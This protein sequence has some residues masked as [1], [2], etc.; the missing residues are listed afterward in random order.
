M[1]KLALIATLA[2]AML[3]VPALAS[4]TQN[5]D[6]LKAL[7][8]QLPS[9]KKKTTVAVILPASLPFAAKVPKLYATGAG[10]RNAWSFALDGA[11]LCG[12]ANACSLASFEAKRGGKLP[13]KSNLKLAGG[14]PAFYKGITCGASCSPATLWFTYHGVLYTL[15]LIHI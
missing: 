4:T 12:S 1:S 10:S 9:V 11:P 13:G 14:Q 5:A 15:S 2:A 3:A 7:A 6:V 8:K